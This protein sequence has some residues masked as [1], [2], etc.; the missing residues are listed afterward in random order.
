MAT[1]LDLTTQPAYD[2]RPTRISAI[3]ETTMLDFLLTLIALLSSG[4]VSADTQ[5]PRPGPQGPTLPRPGDPGP[6]QGF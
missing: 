4:S 2:A 1:L 3:L 6:D 5:D